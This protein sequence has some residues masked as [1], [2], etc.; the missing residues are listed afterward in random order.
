MN[1]KCLDELML[2]PIKSSGVPD[3]WASGDG[4]WI[5]HEDKQVRPDAAKFNI[6]VFFG[7]PLV[8]TPG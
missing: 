8:N 6:P 5:R 7:E 4:M 1:S 2:A 3:A